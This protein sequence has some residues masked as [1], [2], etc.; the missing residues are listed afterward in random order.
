V[1]ERERAWERENVHERERTCM[2]ERER[3]WENIRERESK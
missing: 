1:R 2:R 3:A